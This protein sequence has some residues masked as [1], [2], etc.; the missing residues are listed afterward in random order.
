MVGTSPT[1]TKKFTQNIETSPLAAT[2]DV[3]EA[4]LQAMSTASIRYLMPARDRPE[5][6]VGR[7]DAPVLV[8]ADEEAHRR[9]ARRPDWM[10]C[11]PKPGFE[12]QKHLPRSLMPA[13]AANLDCSTNMKNVIPLAP[14]C[15]LKRATS[16][17]TGRRSRPLR[18]S[19]C[20]GAASPSRG[21]AVAAIPAVARSSAVTSSGE[22]LG[23]AIL[24]SG[25]GLEARHESDGPEQRQS[26]HGEAG[27]P[28]DASKTT[29][30]SALADEAADV[31]GREIEPARGGAVA[32]RRP[33]SRSR[34]RAPAPGTF[35]P[36]SG[37]GRPARPGAG[38][39]RR[40]AARRAPP[41]SPPASPSRA[42]AAW[43]TARLRTSSGSTAGRRDKPTRRSSAKATGAPPPARSSRR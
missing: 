34:W 36:R 3:I 39:R 24:L 9:R 16:R 14:L 17:R 31:V 21:P 6:R 5:I 41:G 13:S 18:A 8:L 22:A 15:R 35:R 29:P 23:H 25:L 42:L 7:P 11:A 43:R 26:D 19:H 10:W 1:M 37:R 28:A 38:T 20:V 27:G 33:G 4:T 32:E 40:V 30:S 2:V 12:Y